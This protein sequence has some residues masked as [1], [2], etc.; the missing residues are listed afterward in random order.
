MSVPP[1]ETTLSAESR[2]N[3]EYKIPPAPCR[4]PYHLLPQDNSTFKLHSYFDTFKSIFSKPRKSTHTYPLHKY[5]Y[6]LV[7]YTH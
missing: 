2:K 1:K 7:T 3:L 5:L 4:E 6:T